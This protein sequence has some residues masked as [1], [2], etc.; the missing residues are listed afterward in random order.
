MKLA[1]KNWLRLISSEGGSIKTRVFRSGFWLGLAHVVLSLL[2]FIRSIILARLLTPEMFG[3]MGM[4]MVV[5][6]AIETF[7]RPGIGQ[8]LIQSRKPFE[9]SSDTAFSLLVMRGMLLAVL[10][11]LASP[12]LAR[13]YG[14][15]RI[16]ELL[17]V[18]SI[19]F[20]IGGFSN[21]YT[22]ARQKEIDF[23]SITLL[24][25]TAA[26]LGT[27]ITVSVAYVMKSVWAL[28]IGQIASSLIQTTLSY[29]FVKGKI[30]FHFDWAI[31]KE[32][33][34]YGKFI[35]GASIIVFLA[36]EIDN[37][38]IA[39]LLG[40]EQL[41]FYVIA[42][43]L[44]GIVT[45]NTS[46]VISSVMLPAYSKLQSDLLALKQ[47]FLSTIGLI[48][49]LVVPIAVG[50]FMLADGIIH[51]I[52]GPQWTQSVVPLQV[53][54]IFGGLLALI[55][56][57]GYL[58]EGIGKPSFSFYLGLVRLG[59]VA[60]SIIPLIN[61]FGLLGA[62]MAVTLGIAVQWVVSF[63][64]MRR[65]IGITVSGYLGAIIGPVWKSAVMG[66]CLYLL[67]FVITPHSLGGL[68][69]FVALGM[70]VYGLLSLRAM[71][72]LRAMMKAR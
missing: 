34:S 42:Y 63:W 5:V 28:V 38:A 41:G 22:V 31:A 43:L 62:G 15:S 12:L 46:K 57:D 16:E 33:L 30:R 35:T 21:I 55:S 51:V 69:S 59:V 24:N 10:M 4:C 47:A 6:R 44:A 29:V 11:F 64:L 27:V 3:L 66:A 23:R 2:S 25:Q 14:E 32:L 8:A 26:V 20:L 9:E 60:A 19:T 58:F 48:S 1:L 53:L 72:S 54:A 45:T 52:Y 67:S 36:R 65:H 50:M 70:L 49:L 7:T 56:I 13:F 68:L 17:Q 40:P 61:Q 18:L 71:H 37:I 39:K